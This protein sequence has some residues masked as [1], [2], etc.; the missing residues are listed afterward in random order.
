MVRKVIEGYHSTIFAYGQT[1]SGKTYTMEGYRYMANDK[2][3]IVPKISDGA[4]P[5][6]WGLVQRCA[7]QLVEEVDKV[8]GARDVTI[9]VSFLEIYNERIYDLLNSSL[10]RRRKAPSPTDPQP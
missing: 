10:F 3:V 1:G 5:E 4:N 9:S 6:T 7:R 2:G 8:K